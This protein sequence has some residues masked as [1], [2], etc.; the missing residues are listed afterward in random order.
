MSLKALHTAARRFCWD[1]EAEAKVLGLPPALAGLAP[2]LHDPFAVC[3]AQRA[4]FDYELEHSWRQGLH[5]PPPAA[6]DRSIAVRAWL[7]AA[8]RDEIE[9][10]VPTDF[11][12]A[13]ELRTFLG[14]AGQRARVI[15]GWTAEQGPDGE[16][17]R[18]V[19]PPPWDAAEQA[20]AAT[21]RADYLEYVAT[22]SEADAARAGPMPYRLVLS[23]AQVRRLRGAC[24]RRWDAD[25]TRGYWFPLKEGDPPADTLIVDAF[26]CDREF[27][28]QAVREL[29]RRRGVDRVWESSEN[30]P[31]EPAVEMATRVC[32]FGGR[33]TM[34][35]SDGLDWL[36]YA[37]HEDS[38]T[39]AGAWLVPAVKAAW[40]DWQE[41]RYEP[42]VERRAA[43]MEAW[44]QGRSRPTGHDT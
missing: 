28:F 10:S 1:A 17:V 37:S 20:A 9:R 38:V 26:R 27:D 42:S 41:A 16:W 7:L 11:R 39:F 25:P 12:S 19:Q 24:L 5:R 3:R 22:V 13:D 29:L 18:H 40:P 32:C 35:S 31:L 6:G 2:S 33:E 30:W 36:I 34:W 21:A 44:R 8:V 4:R 23:E 14:A 43:A 15:G